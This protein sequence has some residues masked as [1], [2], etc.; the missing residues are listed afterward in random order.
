MLRG[1]IRHWNCFWLRVGYAMRDPYDLDYVKDHEASI[2]RNCGD[3]YL[4]K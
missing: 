3:R 4:S 1:I 2:K